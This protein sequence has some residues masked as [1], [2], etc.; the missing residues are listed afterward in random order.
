MLER[1]IKPVPPERENRKFQ[2]SISGQKPEIKKRFQPSIHE[3]KRGDEA[4]LSHRSKSPEIKEGSFTEEEESL[5]AGKSDE[6]ISANGL[7][8]TMDRLA[9]LYHEDKQTEKAMGLFRRLATNE[10]AWYDGYTRRKDDTGA[11]YRAGRWLGYLEKLGDTNTIE[12]AKVKIMS[13]LFLRSTP[14]VEQPNH[15]EEAITKKEFERI[16]SDWA[17]LN[18]QYDDSI[19][20]FFDN[21]NQKTFSPEELDQLASMQQELYKLE[22]RWFQIARGEVTVQQ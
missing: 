2:P 13:T 20:G 12:M 4:E 16:G 9:T 14:H 5:I 6:E 1:I 17:Q 7:W 21:P 19:Q 8:G 22:Q 3:M 18:K 10:E 15:Q 11:L